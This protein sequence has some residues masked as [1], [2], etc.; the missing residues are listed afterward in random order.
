M[1]NNFEK[2]K[3]KFLNKL[4]K[5]APPWLKPLI[6]VIVLIGG[7]AA[8]KSLNHAAPIRVNSQNQSGGITANNVNI[9]SSLVMRPPSPNF[10]C[11]F[12]TEVLANVKELDRILADMPKNDFNISNYKF[13]YDDYNRY[14]PSFGQFDL[15]QQIKNFYVNLKKIPFG[16]KQQDITVVR[17]QG[18]D[19]LRKLTDNYGCQDYFGNNPMLNAV[20]ADTVTLIAEPTDAGNVVSGSTVLIDL[21]SKDSGL[22]QKE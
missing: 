20:S 13:I 9:G 22:K 5:L 11:R 18:K 3:R 1:E 7:M 16:Y 2:D 15:D 14:D 12:Y 8:L 19:V 17:D 6:I 4:W 21:N 10:Q